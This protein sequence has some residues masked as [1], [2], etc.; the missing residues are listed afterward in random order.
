METTLHNYLVIQQLSLKIEERECWLRSCT[1]L[2]FLPCLLSFILADIN[3]H[4]HY[5]TVVIDYMLINVN[6]PATK[7][8]S[9]SQE[10]DDLQFQNNCSV[11]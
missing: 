9:S 5:N 8:I 6:F 7:E 3:F 11:S 2:L 4:A 1:P 10:K